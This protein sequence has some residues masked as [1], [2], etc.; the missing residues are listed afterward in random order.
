[1]SDFSHPYWVSAEEN[2]KRELGNTHEWK[3]KKAGLKK[4]KQ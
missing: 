1:M 2:G 4:K 3:M